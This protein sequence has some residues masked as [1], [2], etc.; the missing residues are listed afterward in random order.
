M[1][2]KACENDDLEIASMLVE[3]GADINFAGNV[4]V[5]IISFMDFNCSVDV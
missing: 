3:A 1:L 2:I 4:S 5:A